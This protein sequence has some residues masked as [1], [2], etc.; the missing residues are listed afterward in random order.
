MNQD[1]HLLVSTRRR[2]QKFCF[3]LTIGF[4]ACMAIQAGASAASGPRDPVAVVQGQESLTE[5]SGSVDECSPMRSIRILGRIRFPDGGARVGVLVDSSLGGAV[6]V[7]PQ[8]EFVLEVDLEASVRLLEVRARYLEPGAKNWIGT[9]TV[10]LHAGVD[11]VSLDGEI[12]MAQAGTCVPEWAATFGMSPGVN[13]DVRAIFSLD[14]GS[15]SGPAIFA[16]GSFTTAGGASLSRLAKW[17][18]SGWTSFGNG[19]LA[20]P[21]AMAIFDD[22]SGAGPVLY[23]GGTGIIQTGLGTGSMARWNGNSWMSFAGPNGPVQSMVVFDDPAGAGN[24]L[25][26]GGSFSTAGASATLNVARWDGQRWSG[27]GEGVNGPV[28]V[29]LG[30][31]G[32]L[33]LGSALYVGGDFS[34]AGGSQAN[35]I[36][37]WNGFVWSPLVLESGG[38]ST[39]FSVLD[40]VVHRESITASPTLFAAGTFFQLGGFPGTAGIARWDGGTTWSSVGGGLAGPADSLASFDDGSGSIPALFVAGSFASA[41]AAAANNIARWN[42]TAWAP[43]G[44]GVGGAVRALVVHQGPVTQS[45]SLFVGGNFLLAGG[46]LANRIAWWGVQGW[47]TIG[48]GLTNTVN[49]LAVFDDGGGS[50][51]DLYIGGAFTW[52]GGQPASRA[53]AWDGQTWSSLGSGLNGPAFAMHVSGASSVAGSGLIVGGDFTTA[54]GQPANRVARW[55]GQGWSALGSGTAGR[56]LALATYDDGAAGG[57]ALYAGGEFLFA[58]G[59]PANRLAR[60][61]G[62]SWSSVGSGLDGP[63]RAL[64]VHNDGTSFGTCLFVGGDFNTAGG[65]PANFIARWNGLSWSAL[66]VGVNGSVRALAVHDDGAGNDLYVGGSFTSAGGQL[67]NRIARWDGDSWSLLAA[68]SIQPGVGPNGTV[69]AITSYEDGGGAGPA[70][71]IAGSFGSIN[72]GP[73]TISVPRVA[74]WR[75]GTWDS[76]GAGVPTQVNAMVSFDSGSGAVLCVGGSFTTSSTGDSFLSAWGGCPPFGFGTDLGCGGNIATLDSFSAGLVLGRTSQIRLRA[77][78]PVSGLG[79]LYAGSLSI[80]TSGCGLPLP[81]IGELLIS[82]LPS[83]L[84]LGTAPTSTGQV[85]FP[86]AVPNNPQLVGQVVSLQGAFLVTSL[87]S[88]PV[89]LSNALTAPVAP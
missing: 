30:N 56:V 42:G 6:D 49:A 75:P 3:I 46:L 76:A 20:G 72:I 65:I 53:I 84:L 83:P 43:L 71:Y 52:A 10:E 74:R 63:V 89:E 32:S 55:D 28:R 77:S 73:S 21:D 85:Q 11:E 64:V 70:L 87:P 69:N 51:P 62:Q 17:D 86:V 48:M 22:G 5:Q 68:Q 79:Q 60:W 81:G 13:G 35:G 12:L 39:N 23:A 9:Q 67:I 57:P 31:D 8:G 4:A 82:L 14:D 33:G 66:G 34:T 15:G 44:S 80:N 37:R 58:G 7:G 40:L 36:A 2:W 47:S 18:G 38:A 41:G 26:V 50:G 16:S 19:L 61:D 27:L 54:G 88:T 24:A 29:L 59:V 25:Y 78:A 45:P 1:S